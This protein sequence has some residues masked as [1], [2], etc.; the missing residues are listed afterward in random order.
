M[1]PSISLNACYFSLN[2]DDF[3]FMMTQMNFSCVLSS[4]V[5][6][7]LAAL[8][9]R[10]FEFPGILIVLCFGVYCLPAPFVLPLLLPLFSV[11]SPLFSLVS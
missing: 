7:G 8:P 6:C 9:F 10:L 11:V 2:C 1:Q 5:A 3:T 4:A